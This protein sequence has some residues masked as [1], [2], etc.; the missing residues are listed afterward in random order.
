MGTDENE[1][2]S[3]SLEP[4]DLVVPRFR[5][6]HRCGLWHQR[7]QEPLCDEVV[8]FI[9]FNHLCL[10]LA[11]TNHEVCVLVCGV[12]MFGW[13]HGVLLKRVDL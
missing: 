11:V 3:P 1:V 8:G 5:A 4:S 6:N 10:V 2:T 12:G 13:V 7:S 9:E